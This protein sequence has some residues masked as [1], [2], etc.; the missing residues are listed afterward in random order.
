MKREFRGEDGT[1]GFVAAWDSEN[2][3]AGKGEQEII[4]IC[5]FSKMG[6]Q[7]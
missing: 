2:P 7:W 6:I 5:N 4:G 1:V 3:D